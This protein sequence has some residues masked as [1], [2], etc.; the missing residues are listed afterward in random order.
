MASDRL[1]GTRE[2]RV[3]IV[4]AETRRFFHREAGW[5]IARQGIVCGR[6]VGDEIEAL[7][8]PSQ[9]GNDLGSVAKDPDRQSSAFT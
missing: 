9:L 1:T 5:D 8:P 2:V 7:A 3:W 4:F 6:L